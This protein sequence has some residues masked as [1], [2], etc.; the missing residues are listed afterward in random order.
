MRLG[1]LLGLTCAVQRAARLAYR[2]Y[3][4]L[5]DEGGQTE[6]VWM[7]FWIK[8]KHFS[9]SLTLS[10]LGQGLS[11]PDSAH[12]DMPSHLQGSASTGLKMWPKRSGSSN[13]YTLL[14]NSQIHR[15]S[16]RPDSML[17]Q[18]TGVAQSPNWACKSPSPAAGQMEVAQDPTVAHSMEF[19]PMDGP[20]AAHPA[21]CTKRLSTTALLQAYLT[22]FWASSHWSVRSQLLV[23]ISLLRSEKTMGK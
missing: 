19:L 2:Y 20:C 23:N 7:T 11:S 12:G 15:E 13:C 1:T 8:L 6:K 5:R 10:A 14:P 22:H 21:R 9:F 16:C 4:D 3:L 18:C 17:D